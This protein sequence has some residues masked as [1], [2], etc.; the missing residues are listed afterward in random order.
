MSL[1]KEIIMT[2]F[3]DVH[4]GSLP[5][6]SS[7]WIA[8]LLQTDG[9][10]S[11]AFLRLTFGL[12]L[13]PHGAQ[14]LFGLFGGYGFGPTIEWMTSTLGVPAPVAA[15]SILLEFF[16]PLLLIAGL[17]TRPVA[18]SLAIFMGVAAATHLPNGF[19]MNWFG[20]MAAGAEGFEYHLLAIAMLVT[21]AIRGAG[22]LSLDRV[23]ASR[24]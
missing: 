24:S 16:G 23:L 5:R 6:A 18:A 9:S 11:Q 17:A 19:F 22:A 14:H 21:I 8:T 15:A 13:L 2:T 1:T 7:G 3:T 20:T 10:Y 4:S 12:V